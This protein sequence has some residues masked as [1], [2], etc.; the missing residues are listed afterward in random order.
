MTRRT[1]GPVRSPL[2]HLDSNE[3]GQSVVREVRAR[4]HHL[5]PVSVYR[6]WARRTESV[7][8]AIIDAVE[9]DF[10]GR[11]T[12]AD[13]FAGGGVIALS[14]LLAGHQV[15]AQDVNPWAARSL[16][17]MLDLPSASEIEAAG[18]R[19]RTLMLPTLEGA[20]S[21]TLADGT[22]AEVAHTLRVAT[23]GCP[24]CDRTLRL[25]P[26]AT[27]SLLDRVDCGGEAGYVACR[28]GHLQLG[29]STGRQTCST[30]A[31]VIDPQARYTAGRC[32]ACSTCGWQGKLSD[33]TSTRSFAWEIALVERATRGRREVALPSPHE[34]AVAS[35]DSW[36]PGRTLDS[37]SP[38]VETAVLRR[39]GFSNWA[40]L[41]PAR[42]RV[43]LETMLQHCAAAAEGDGRVERALLA[44]ILGSVEM[45]GYASRWDARYLKPYE[46]VSNHR[47][48]MTTLSAEPNVWGVAAAGRGTVSRRIDHI[49]KA[50]AWLEER[51]GR[52]VLLQGL[53]PPTA[54]RTRL[55]HG[56]DARIV[57][58]SSERLALQ[59]ESLDLV[60][61]DPPYHDDVQYGELSDIFRTWAG[62]TTGALDGDAI[63]RRASTT[64][65]TDTYR[66]LLALVF[67][68]AFRALR[69]EGHLILSY[70]NRQP[71]AW[72]ALFEALQA[73][74]FRAV[75]YE[76]VR[77]E[78]EIDHAKAGKRACTFDVLI[79][80]VPGG[81]QRV[82]LHRPSA[83]ASSDETM[84]CELVGEQAL[85]I[86]SLREGW[87]D[88]FD[89]KLRR[90]AFLA[91][92]AGTAGL[93]S[94]DGMPAVEPGWQSSVVRGVRSTVHGS[95]A[96]PRTRF[97]QKS[98]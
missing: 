49:A 61:T 76:I 65:T 78:N 7:V 47:F 72:I 74:G 29:S 93:R 56:T 66:D 97:V 32:T 26:T 36:I 87:T 1:S 15:Y 85:H 23:A 20:Y 81:C 17:T 38:G 39:H 40:D 68:E 5:P 82:E 63:V 98:T 89:D 12:I 41:Y 69:R 79:D 24:S 28:A 91:S 4:Q 90:S 60:L 8:S 14:A 94:A 10:E 96:P 52:R 77:S 88:A 18:E 43:V 84:F 75:G 34:L 73:A 54:L 45:A 51:L 80:L 33:L 6:W 25:F 92:P 27:V 50:A 64:A 3:I 55:A 35:A 58:G 53:L 2:R 48:T 13:P 59:K 67:R 16:V 70:A 21:T 71:R 9:E 46:T 62:I 11:L 42:Q 19:L 86:G 95:T 83:R 31:G 30:C 57:E 37:I 22:T 44:A